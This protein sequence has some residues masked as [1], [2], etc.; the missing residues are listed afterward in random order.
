VVE[1]SRSRRYTANAPVL[2]E[3]FTAAERNATMWPSA[4]SAGSSDRLLPGAPFGPSAR[5]ARIVF[6]AARS[7]TNTWKVAA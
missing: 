2:G 6:P 4:L 5:L 1:A 7:R 3:K